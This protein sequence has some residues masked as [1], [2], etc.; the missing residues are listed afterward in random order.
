MTAEG[1]GGWPV[2][3]AELVIIVEPLGQ[4][5][6]DI[7]FALCVTLID[8]LSTA[9]RGASLAKTKTRWTIRQESIQQYGDTAYWALIAAVEANG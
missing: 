8:N 9:L 1:Q 5:V 6:N 7:N 3:R 2:L 4:N